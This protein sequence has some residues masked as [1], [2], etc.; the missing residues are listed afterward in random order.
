[1]GVSD[2]H[3]GAAFMCWNSDDDPVNVLIIPATTGGTLGHV[4][5]FSGRRLLGFSSQVLA[6]RYMWYSLCQVYVNGKHSRVYPFTVPSW[7][8]ECGQSC[9]GVYVTSDPSQFPD[10]F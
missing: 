8:L 6:H 2:W 1:M 7:L 3:P 4:V 9:I 10:F 5:I